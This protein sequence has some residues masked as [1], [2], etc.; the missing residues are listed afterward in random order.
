MRKFDI[1]PN[2]NTYKVININKKFNVI[3]N[4]INNANKK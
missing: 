4:K 2:A 3:A 1:K